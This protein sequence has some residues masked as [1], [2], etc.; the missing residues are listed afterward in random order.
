MN[1]FN[2]LDSLE[3]EQNKAKLVRSHPLT[4]IGLVGCELTVLIWMV[5]IGGF[6]M[7]MKD[8]VVYLGR[9]K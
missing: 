7:M 4:A 5:A 9:R 6:I 3:S 1:K 2:F 8:I